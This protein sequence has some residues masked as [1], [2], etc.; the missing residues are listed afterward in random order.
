MKDE[1]FQVAEDFVAVLAEEL[2][3]VDAIELCKD[4]SGHGD[5]SKERVCLIFD[6]GFHAEGVWAAY[7]G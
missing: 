5:F 6:F 1:C 4:H 2:G 3:V 7:V